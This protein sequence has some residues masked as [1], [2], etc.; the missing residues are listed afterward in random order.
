MNTYLSGKQ[1]RKF[2]QTQIE[3][4]PDKLALKRIV[5]SEVFDHKIA[6]AEYV[7]G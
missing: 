4:W 1:G 7:S 2:G 3:E 6:D 5:R